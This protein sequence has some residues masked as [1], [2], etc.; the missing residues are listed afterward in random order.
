MKG[1]LRCSSSQLWSSCKSLLNAIAKFIELHLSRSSKQKSLELSSLLNILPDWANPLWFIVRVEL[2]QILELHCNFTVQGCA[3]KKGMEIIKIISTR[4][5][6]S[7]FFFS[8]F[9]FFP[10]KTKQKKLSQHLWNQPCFE[11]QFLFQKFAMFK[12]EAD[13]INREKKDGK[14]R[15][16]GGKEGKR[17]RR[18]ERRKWNIFKRFSLHFKGVCHLLFTFLITAMM[19]ILYFFLL[20]L[21]LL[22]CS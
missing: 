9:F 14:E 7:L 11:M 3:L 15:K 16:E 2:F 20:F 5:G 22:K 6:W 13:Y 10:K 17:N 18:K 8:F 19:L 1:R 4:K 12:I 21:F